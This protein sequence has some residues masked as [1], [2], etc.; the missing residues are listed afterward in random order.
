MTWAWFEEETVDG[1]CVEEWPGKDGSWEQRAGSCGKRRAQ[2]QETW[3]EAGEESLERRGKIQGAAKPHWSNGWCW[4]AHL[5][6]AKVRHSKKIFST[7]FFV[8]GLLH[9]IWKFPG[10][11]TE[12]RPELWPTPQLWQ[13]QNLNPLHRTGDWTSDST[14]ASQIINPLRHSGNCSFSIHF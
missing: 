2:G 11:K 12:S 10:Q 14:E 8:F 3:G 6:L 7:F 1:V 5:D 9:C 4:L 13:H